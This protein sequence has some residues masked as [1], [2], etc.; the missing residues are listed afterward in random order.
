MNVTQPVQKT[1]FV[2]E[3]M[4]NANVK[5]TMLDANVTNVKMDFTIIPIVKL[6]IV[7]PKELRSKFAM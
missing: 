4:V 3:A 5:I 7:T 6:V 1:K 2:I